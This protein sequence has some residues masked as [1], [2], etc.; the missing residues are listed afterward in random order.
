L[1]TGNIYSS[2]ITGIGTYYFLVTDLDT[3]TGCES[4]A[5]TSTLIV[6]LS[7]SV[8]MGQDVNIC[9]GNPV[10]PLVVSGTNV[11]WYSDTLLTTLLSIGNSYNTGNTNTGVYTYYLIDSIGS[12]ASINYGQITLSINPSP[13]IPIA[14]DQTICYGDPAILTSTGNNP[15]W[16]SDPTLINFIG[17]G[18]Q[19]YPTQNQAGIYEFYVA[20]FALGCG[21][22]EPDTVKL[23]IYPRPLITANT[24]YTSIYVGESVNLIAYNAVSYVWS[25]P[26]GLNTTTGASVIASPM[27][28][29]TYTV[30]GTNA[31]GCSSDTSIFVVVN[32]ISVE[33]LGM[34]FEDLKIY[35][36]PASMQFNVEFSTTLS[37]PIQIY[38]NNVLGEKVLLL[39]IEENNGPG[40]KA[41][42]Y[43]IDTKNLADGFYSLE[44]ISDKGSISRRIILKK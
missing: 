24:F 2:G 17:N 9:L 29:T 12:C 42:K 22:S 18:N 4:Q 36:N 25:P 43:V 32:P 33:E 5:D 38:M 27:V 40:L 7:P 3:L 44:F 35:P 34:Y 14:E 37:S 11:R 23:T 6:S 21:H 19:Y 13:I 26:T 16:Y 31:Y 41:H 28:N 1:Y 20:D 8:P 30:T 10:P 15:Q 39:D